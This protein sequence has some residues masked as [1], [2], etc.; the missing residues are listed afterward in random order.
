MHGHPNRLA[1]LAH[2]FRHPILTAFSM[3]WMLCK[4]RDLSCYFD[5]FASTIGPSGEGVDQVT[6]GIPL[7]AACCVSLHAPDGN[8]A[9]PVT[10]FACHK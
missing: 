5:V 1:V 3:P 9:A 8:P 7:I 6:S 4:R 2:R 10:L